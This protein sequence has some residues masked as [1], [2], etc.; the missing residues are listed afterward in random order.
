MLKQH[1]RPTR[2]LLILTCALTVA[3]TVLT[4]AFFV[5]KYAPAGAGADRP[6]DS[7]D[8]SGD[9]PLGTIPDG[10]TLPETPDAGKSYQ[11]SLIFVGDSLTAHLINREALTGGTT[12]TQVWRTESGIFNLKPGMNAQQIIFPGPG[13]HTGKLLTVAEAATFAEPRILIVTLGADWGVA[14]LSEQDFKACYTDFIRRIKEASPDTTVILQSI[15]PVTEDCRVLTNAQIDLANKWVKAIAADTDCP[16]LDTQSILKD[17]KGALKA[18]FC[19]SS[20]G[21]H[22][23]ADAYGA[24]LTYIR[25]HAVR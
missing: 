18:E 9:A 20:D 5:T 3:L 1:V 4:V 25:T 12:T 23:N 8:P 11:D 22:L 6:S 10:I 17:D 21:I 13:E 2:I 15:F 14:Y 24:I 16:Y 7:A 19:H